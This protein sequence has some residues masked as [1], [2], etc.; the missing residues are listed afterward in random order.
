MERSS[1]RVQR[2]QQFAWFGLIF[3]AIALLSLVYLK[4]FFPVDPAAFA[5]FLVRCSFIFGALGL[6]LALF[7]LPHKIGF[8]GVAISLINWFVLLFGWPL[9][10]V[11]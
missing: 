11:F 10:A 6:T 4:L 3:S 8:T 5:L 1:S 2:K 9:Y 7:S